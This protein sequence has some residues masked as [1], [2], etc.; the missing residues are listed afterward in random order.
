MA[1][2]NCIYKCI[3]DQDRVVCVRAYVR[4]TTAAAAAACAKAARKKRDDNS[5][6]SGRVR[7]KVLFLRWLVKPTPASSSA[8]ANVQRKGFQNE[9]AIVHNSD[10]FRHFGSNSRAV[11]ANKVQ[12]EV[13]CAARRAY[14]VTWLAL[15]R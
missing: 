1:F 12:E 14:F 13:F 7:I 10:L 4:V 2:E 9:G 5:C 8:R 3:W 15:Q 11:K 6:Q